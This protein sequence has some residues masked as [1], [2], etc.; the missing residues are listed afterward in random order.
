MFQFAK[1]RYSCTWDFFCDTCYKLKKQL[2]RSLAIF[3][4]SDFTPFSFGN[5]RL[6]LLFSPLC[7]IIG[8]CRFRIRRINQHLQFF[9]AFF[10]ITN[11][12]TQVLWN[13]ISQTVINLT[14]IRNI[15]VQV[16][17][18]KSLCFHANFR[19]HHD[20]HIFFIKCTHKQTAM[21]AVLSFKVSDT[22]GK[23]LCQNEM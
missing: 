10:C 7:S 22:E 1:H 15:V 23:G 16:V 19:R 3:P 17:I 14:A 21:I 11:H 12:I 13:F 4:H 2:I 18:L 5:P 8:I 9:L 6:I 20:I